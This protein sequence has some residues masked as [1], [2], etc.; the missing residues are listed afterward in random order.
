MLT[1]TPTPTPAT[2]CLAAVAPAG[3]HLPGLDDAATVATRTFQ[4]TQRLLAQ[5][6]SVNGIAAVSGPPGCGKTFAVDHFMR[7]HPLMRE[8]R[9]HWLDMPPKPT[10]KEVTVRL[11]D[12]LG[13]HRPRSATEYELTELL[14]PALNEG[15][16]VIVIDEAQNLKSDGLQ[17]LRYL[18]DRGQGRSWTLAL[19]G[20]TVNQALN[21]AAELG[22][23]VSRWVTFTPLKGTEQLLPTLRDW[24]PV[25]S[26]L[27]PKLLLRVDEVY[28]RGNFRLWAQFL[29][30]LLTLTEIQAGG[31]GTANQAGDAEHQT[32]LVSAAL[33]AVSPSTVRAQ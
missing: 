12:A 14:A 19:V 11:L 5:T 32:L 28:A 1:T 6:V 24:H 30:A 9:W 22:S 16:P 7:T 18:H 8:R 23:R 2:S 20:S 10:T 4:K 27:S 3:R 31:A 25:L 13:E 29:Q 26:V 17:Q 21:G 33:A 15:H